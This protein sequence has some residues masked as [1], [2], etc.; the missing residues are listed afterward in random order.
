MKEGGV[1]SRW[2]V[3]GVRICEIR[4]GWRMFAEAERGRYLWEELE[5]AVG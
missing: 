3:V 1:D 5:L 2:L 4:R